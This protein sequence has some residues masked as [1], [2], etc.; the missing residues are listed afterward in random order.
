MEMLRVMIAD[1]SESIRTALADALRGNY[2]VKLCQDG[3]QALE[4]LNIFCPDVLVL[5]LMLPEVDGITLLQTAAASGFHPMVL[6]TTRFIS[7]YVID[8]VRQLGV[9]YLMMKPYDV[10]AL[11]SRIEDLSQRLH[12]PMVIQP[13]P[14]DTVSNILLSLGVPTKL[15]GYICMRE[16]ILCIRRDP[17]QSITKELY[18]AVAE[19][20]GG[21]A[22]QVE[23]AI[24]SAIHTA[25]STGDRNIWQRYFSCGPDGTV[26]RPTNAAFLSR[27]ADQLGREREEDLLEKTG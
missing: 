11:V 2:H 14:R 20:T 5:D 17:H 16:A 6:A 22:E 15:R 27:I 4:Q 18:P 24:R 9:G 3:A 12:T 25:W 23:R 21:T 10:T 8:A 7:D 1:S 13:D 26:V 19:I